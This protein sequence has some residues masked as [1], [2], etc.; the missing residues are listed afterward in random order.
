MVSRF[1]GKAQTCILYFRGKT[2]A[3]DFEADLNLG[4]FLS[5]RADVDVQSCADQRGNK[6]LCPSTKVQTEH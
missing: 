2:Q 4:L 5:V 1:T 3:L 6:P